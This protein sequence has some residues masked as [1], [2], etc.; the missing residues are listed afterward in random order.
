MCC[1]LLT[2]C[3]TTNLLPKDFAP[4]DVTQMQGKALLLKSMQRRDPK[5][6][7]SQLTFMKVIAKDEWRS[8]TARLFTPIP[9][10]E[11]QIQFAF[12]L[13]NDEAFLKFIDGDQAGKI[14]GIERGV[15]YF[16]AKGKRQEKSSR[17][18]DSYL[19][20]VKN[21]FLWPQTLH[22]LHNITY[23]GEA[24]HGLRHYYK[25]LA[26]NNEDFAAEPDD[27]Y[28]LWVNQQTLHIEYIEF[29]LKELSASY[30]GLV[31]YREYRDVD[32]VLLPHEIILLDG[33]DTLSYSHK[34]YVQILTL[35]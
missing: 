26:T 11:Q 34:F 28:I 14:I 20:P 4:T 10:E 25:I 13:Q 9:Q 31:Q 27:Q 30:R 7:W 3:S 1:L 33:M 22:K 23:L 15:T 24:E 2:G 18:V 17:R 21:Y 19:P 35:Q 16:L 32:G 6:H 12:N 8:Q 29:T 5:D